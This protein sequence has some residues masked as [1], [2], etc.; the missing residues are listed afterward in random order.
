MRVVFGAGFTG[1]RVAEL[2]AARGER[3]VAAVRSEE[4]SAKL[5]DHGFVVTRMSPVEVAERWVDA[6]AHAIVCFP[7]DGT[8]DAALAPHLARA[9]AVSY[10]S[11]TGV[12][13]DREGVID[14]LTPVMA[15]SSRVL[16]AEAMYRDIGGTVLRAPGI[17]GTDR[18]L[19]VRVRTGKHALPG[20]GL[21]F[22]SRIHVDDLAELLLAS[23]AVRGET[24]V[25]GDREPAT[26]REVVSWIC[27]TYGCPFPP[28]VPAEKVHESL[29]RNRR[30]DA[31]RVLETLGVT[32]RYPTYREGM[33]P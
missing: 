18:G 10:V 8:T 31:R 14:D 16:E 27:A 23:D 9:R 24:F 5:Q 2:A 17:Y 15:Q 3:V 13:G 28:S 6:E 12:Y 11:T 22:T 29:R 4:R 25:V 32:L 20:D 26:Q 21:G 33:A 1:S 19:H 30:I 7:P